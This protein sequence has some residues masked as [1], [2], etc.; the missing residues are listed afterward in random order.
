VFAASKYILNPYPDDMVPEDEPITT[1]AVDE[2]EES[3]TVETDSTGEDA[4]EESEISA[5]DADAD[6][7]KEEDQG[8]AELRSDADL[9]D[10]AS[11]DS[12]LAGASADSGIETET[13]DYE[14]ESD[15]QPLDEAARNSLN[16]T[17]SVASEDFVEAD[18]SGRNIPGL[19][20]VA[21]ANLLLVAVLGAQ[22]LWF[23]RDSLA[24]REDL[25]EYY[26]EVCNFAESFVNCT[27]PDY[28]NLKQISTRRLIVRSHP[29][30]DK[31]LMIDAI[32]LNSG[33]FAQPFPGLELTFSDIEFNTVASRRFRA[34]EYLAGELAGLGYM[35]GGTEV[36]IALEII[37]P[38][39]EAISYELYAV[40]ASTTGQ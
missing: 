36:R 32:I 25:R 16:D 18:A 17:I 15:I 29:R 6:E 35:P 10:W 7:L 19:I 21:C 38:G 33:E 31:A 24:I 11:G 3:E 4:S 20:L 8:P 26:L 12:D 13:S 23:N 37:D 28:I 39:D 34:N 2:Y 27:L 22:F 5:I 30:I 1:A 14:I 9:L 40:P